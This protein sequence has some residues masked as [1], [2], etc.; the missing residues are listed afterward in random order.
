M[1]TKREWVHNRINLSTKVAR[2][3]HKVHESTIYLD[4]S[5]EQDTPEPLITDPV[6]S[7]YTV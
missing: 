6:E 1:P 2:C 4:T 7:S 5:R 3:K